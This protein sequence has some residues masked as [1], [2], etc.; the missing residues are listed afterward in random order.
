MG[1]A[2]G[3]TDLLSCYSLRC[4]FYLRIQ[5]AT[6]AI[7][8]PCRHW[9]VEKEREPIPFKNLTQT[10]HVSFLLTCHWLKRS[11]MLM[12]MY[13]RDWEMWSLFWGRVSI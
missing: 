10:S 6:L 12:P 7:L 8:T 13:K 5:M 4:G 3:Q 2:Q 1:E 11:H 9:E